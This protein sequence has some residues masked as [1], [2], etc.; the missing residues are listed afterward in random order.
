MSVV[1]STDV[2]CAHH[3]E[4][5]CHLQCH[6]LQIK[7][8]GTNRMQ[9]CTF[10]PPTPLSSPVRWGLLSSAPSNNHICLFSWCSLLFT[11]LGRSHRNTP[12]TWNLKCSTCCPNWA[13]QPQ[14]N[15]SHFLAIIKSS[16]QSTIKSEPPSPSPVS[17]HNHPRCASATCQWR[18]GEMAA[19]AQRDEEGFLTARIPCPHADGTLWQCHSGKAEEIYTFSP[20]L[21]KYFHKPEDFPQTI[22]QCSK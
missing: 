16:L 2:R 19:A 20:S 15:N 3:R 14:T 7:Q 8:R 4:E 21:G 5:L 1:V 6:Q 11:W 17:Q 10:S 18:W 22:L 13:L 12:N 9:M